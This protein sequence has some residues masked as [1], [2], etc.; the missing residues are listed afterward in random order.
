MSLMGGLFSL[1]G[2]VQGVRLLASRTGDHRSRLC[3]V[4]ALAWVAFMIANLVLRDWQPRSLHTLGHLPYLLIP[5]LAFSPSFKR[6][7]PSRR[8]LGICG[9]AV[10][11]AA[12]TAL[13]Q[14]FVLGSVALGLMKNPIYFAYNV[15]PAFLFF[16]EM[17]R[18]AVTDQRLRAFTRATAVAAFIGIVLS[19][20]RMAWLCTALY[21]ASRA[22]P[23]LHRRWGRRSLGICAILSLATVFALYQTQDRFREKF[24]RSFSD[25]DPSRVWRFKAWSHNLA[26]F[27]AHPIL[28]VGPERNAIDVDKNRELRG[29]WQPGRLY[30]A[31]S[32][33]IQSLADSGIVGTALLF[34]FLILFG[35]C[36]P[37]TQIYLLFM[38]FMGLT[39]NIFNNSRPAHAF[40]FFL[41]LSAWGL[42]REEVSRGSAR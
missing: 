19:E 5:L 27:R 33:Y 18:S 17:S 41:L 24:D 28:G 6:S 4:A 30:F 25:H 21:L 37:G 14:Y 42:K 36:F 26:L 29:H 23:L 34:G 10:F 32:I 8:V 1:G 15:F 13:Y 11:I 12:L 31:H 9:L 3:A 38:G 39:E 16:A 40:Y 2:A 7:G 20:N 35:L 22:L